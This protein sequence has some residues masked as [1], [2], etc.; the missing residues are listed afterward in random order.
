MSGAG[1]KPR[2]FVYDPL[3]GPKRRVEFRPRDDGEFVRIE[4][5]WTGCD[6]RPLGSERVATVRQA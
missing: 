1:P 2:G 5:V 6:W 4:S 3:R